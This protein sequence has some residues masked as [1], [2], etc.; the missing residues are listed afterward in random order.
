MLHL[1][2]NDKSTDIQV[3]LN[4]NCQAGPRVFLQ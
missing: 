1:S 2:K 3:Y 4:K